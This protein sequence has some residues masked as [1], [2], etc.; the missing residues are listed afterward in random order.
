MVDAPEVV[1]IAALAVADEVAG[2]VDPL[3]RTRREG[4]GHEAGGGQVRPPQVAP[5]EPRAAQ[6]QFAGLADRHPFELRA[7]QIHRSP[8]ER[9]PDR[10]RLR[11]PSLHQCPGRI[12][13]VLRGSVQVV[14][15]MEGAE[16]SVQ[17]LDQ[18]PAQRFSG[19]IDGAHRRGYP[20]GPRQLRACGRDGVDQ[21]DLPRRRQVREGE[22]VVGQDRPAAQRGHHEQLEDRQVEADRGR[23]QDSRQL[24]RRIDPRGPAGEGDDGA[25]LDRDP[26]RTAGRSRGVD[27]V[28]EVALVRPGRQRRRALQL[29]PRPVAVEED[30][31]R[32]G[33]REATGEAL[34]GEQEEGAAVRQDIR[35]PLLGVG[36][37]HGH[38]GAPRLEHGVH[39]DHHLGGAL[40]ADRDPHLRPDPPLDQETRELVGARVQ[41][42][43]GDPLLAGDKD[44]RLGLGRRAQLAGL[45]QQGHPSQDLQGALRPGGRT[46]PG[47]LGESTAYDVIRQPLPPLQAAVR[48]PRTEA[49]RR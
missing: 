6:V 42:A 27:D 22:S 39:G 37:V 3:A 36:G 1:Q 26:F 29:D 19:K 13:G 41:L 20:A 34:L 9:A 28:G 46:A 15:L 48:S 31:R 12:G 2:G 10:G 4:V 23:R 35:L 16:L 43:A 21:R 49:P 7:Q 17:S 25:V 47:Q 30:R 8:L 33:P 40:G 18:S 38:V 45:V 32:R 5:R 11:V 44:H 14:D 24:L